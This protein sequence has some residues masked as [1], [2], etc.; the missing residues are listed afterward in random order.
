M[1]DE[2]NNKLNLQSYAIIALIISTLV[3]ITTS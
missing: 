1:N 2:N 3:L